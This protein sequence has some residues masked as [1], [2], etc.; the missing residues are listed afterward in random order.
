MN[1]PNNAEIRVVL[2]IVLFLVVIV[3]GHLCLCR[4]AERGRRELVLTVPGGMGRLLEGVGE[5]RDGK[6][7]CASVVGCVGDGACGEG[8]TEA[9]LCT[10]VPDALDVA[11]GVV[12]SLVNHIG[13]YR[14]SAI[15]ARMRW[16]VRRCV[17]GCLMI[18][19]AMC[20]A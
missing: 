16:S 17:W 12:A 1:G 7:N 18:F 15:V 10:V 5:R 2:L 14:L 11:A 3:G 9:R 4:L 20:G 13:W 6:S 19:H 8:W